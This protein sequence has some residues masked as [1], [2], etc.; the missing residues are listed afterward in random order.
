MAERKMRIKEGEN[1]KK[2]AETREIIST[3]WK[4]K[5]VLSVLLFA[6][7][8]MFN[9]AIALAQVQSHNLSEIRRVDANFDMNNKNITNV[10]RIGVGVTAPQAGLDIQ[11]VSEY[12]GLRKGLNVLIEDDNPSSDVYGLYANATSNDNSVYGVYAVG[13]ITGGVGYGVYGLGYDYGVYGEGG[14]YGLF[15]QGST[16]GVYAK[17]DSYPIFAHRTS[18][19]YGAAVYAWQSPQLVA[20]LIYNLTGVN[21]KG[22]AVYGKSPGFAGL[23]EGNVNV[24]GNIT[25]GTGTV[26]I[27]GTN[28]RLGIGT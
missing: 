26:F 15:G 28:S 1:M 11:T 22:V 23:F 17:S 16:Y 25:A 18:A 5:I 3:R 7:M 4:R 6:V 19:T 8:F 27:D 2:E 20:G 13:N 14:T 21:K 10:S 9:I 24:T 12:V